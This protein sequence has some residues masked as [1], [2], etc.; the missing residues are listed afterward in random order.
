VIAEHSL[1][2]GRSSA[3]VY[4]FLVEQDSWAALDPATVDI[5]PRG[6]VHTGMTGTITRRV[7]GLRVKNGWLVTE[8]DPS[9]RLGMRITGPGYAL[10]ETTT[11][12]ST[13]DGTRATVVDVL[14]PTSIG[15]RLLVAISGPFIR[16]DLRARTGRLKSPLE[17][18]PAT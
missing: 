11:L 13:P 2:I 18:D 14:E 12:E 4:A 7:I 5:T 8:L 3:Q 17:A 15:G 6:E 16:R 9:A 10:T 1:Q